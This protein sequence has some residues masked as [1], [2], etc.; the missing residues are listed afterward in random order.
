MEIQDPLNP[1]PDPNP[2]SDN[3]VSGSQR[4]NVMTSSFPN[5][6]P[7]LPFRGSYHRRSQSEV[8]FRI[9]DDVDL[10]SDPFDA[11]SASFEELASEDDLF[12]T[13]MDIDKFGSKL[14]DGSAQKPDNVG[15]SG[16]GA[17]HTE[18]GG[19]DVGD[20]EKNSRPRHRHSNSVDGSSLMD[21]IEAKKAMAPDKLA[22]LWAIDPKRAK[23]YAW[24][25][26]FVYV[27]L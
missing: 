9:P 16:S 5:P 26:I 17:V 10:L 19:G 15:G 6:N 14:D 7:S 3:K 1:D 20:G 13:Y 2:C 24:S 25:Y 21:T 12:C 11:P 23:R 22:E 8:H 18:S 4:P 27:G